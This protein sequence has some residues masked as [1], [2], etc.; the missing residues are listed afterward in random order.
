VILTNGYTFTGSTLPVDNAMYRFSFPV[1]AD[2]QG[3]IVIEGRRSPSATSANNVFL[4]ALQLTAAQALRVG[5]IELASPTTLRLIVTGVTEGDTYT[6]EEKIDIDDAGW[7]EV[8]GAT[9]GPVV[10]GAMEIT[11]PRPDTATRFYQVVKPPAF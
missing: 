1:T 3:S 11:I 4:N 5:S 2:A 7:T 10:G 8:P 9:F 6:V